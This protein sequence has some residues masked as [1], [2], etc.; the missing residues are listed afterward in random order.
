MNNM[1][2]PSCLLT[3]VVIEIYLLKRVLFWVKIRNLSLVSIRSL[4]SLWSLWKKMFSDRSDHSNHKE[5]TFQRSQRQRSLGKIFCYL[6]DR[7]K[8]VSIWSLWSLRSLTFF[9]SAIA[10]ITAIVAIIW[11]PGFKKKHL[12]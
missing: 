12:R 10:A 11:K 1:I 6:S 4:R 5:I 7:W 9:V 3:I 2:H 8:V